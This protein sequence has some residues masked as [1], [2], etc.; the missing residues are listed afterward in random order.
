MLCYL[1]H[2]WSTCHQSSSHSCCPRTMGFDSML[3]SPLST[4]CSTCHKLVLK[5]SAG[6]YFL[7]GLVFHWLCLCCRTWCI[8]TVHYDTAQY[9]GLP[10]CVH[11]CLSLG[12]ISPTTQQYTFG[13]SMDLCDISLRCGQWKTRPASRSTQ[14]VAILTSDIRHPTF[15]K[16]A[17]F[18]R[19]VCTSSSSWDNIRIL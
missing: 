10:P 18:L 12:H 19:V 17:V 3:S 5:H 11:G 2:S 1:F 7:R 15:K 9:L 16:S 13:I 8:I 4:C 6:Y 14:K